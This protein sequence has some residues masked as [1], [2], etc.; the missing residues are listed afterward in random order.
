MAESRSSFIGA[1][2]LP[3]SLSAGTVS[4]VA[5]SD[6]LDDCMAES[7]SSF[8]GAAAAVLLVTAGVVS[9]VALSDPLDD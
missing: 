9:L 1:A 8:I 7:R 5:L 2:V 3:V 6:P 4:V